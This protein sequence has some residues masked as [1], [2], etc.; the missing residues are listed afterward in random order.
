MLRGNSNALV[1]SIKKPRIYPREA[2]RGDVGGV[3]VLLYRHD[4]VLQRPE[5]AVLLGEHERQ[6]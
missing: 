6:G 5:R 1:F 2:D 3:E 4:V